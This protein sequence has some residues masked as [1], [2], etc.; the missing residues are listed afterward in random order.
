M[1]APISAKVATMNIAR[2][3]INCAIYEGAMV[4]AM[5]GSDNERGFSG[6]G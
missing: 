2:G 3:L 6:K 1:D 4:Q 5:A